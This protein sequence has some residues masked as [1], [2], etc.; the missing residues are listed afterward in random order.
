MYRY[1]LFVNFV[2]CPTLRKAT[3][4]RKLK[5]IP[6]KK[7][8]AVVAPATHMVKD[9]VQ[10][11]RTYPAVPLTVDCVIFGF[12][13]NK[14]KVLLIK[15]DLE[16]YNGQYSLLGDIVQDNEDLNEAAYRVLKQR[17]GMSDVFLEQ[18]KVFGGPGRHP[19]GRVVTIAYCSLLNIN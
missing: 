18:V 15:S 8:S 11:V 16:I 4:R 7:T 14:L 10:L 3:C 12:E 13:E 1:S 9:A 5:S 19:G 17:T 2:S 6:M